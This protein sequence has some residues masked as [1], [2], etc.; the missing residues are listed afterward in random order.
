MTSRR[1]LRTLLNQ[2]F[3]QTRTMPL[4][5]AIAWVREGRRIEREWD[6]SLDEGL[7]GRNAQD[8]AYGEWRDGARVE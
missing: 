5:W 6:R 8:L 3:P 4:D 2:A 7:A 1:R